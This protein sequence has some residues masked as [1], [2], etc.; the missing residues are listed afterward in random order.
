MSR[1][2][3][4]PLVDR[5]QSELH[6]GLGHGQHQ[7]K[8]H[9]TFVELLHAIYP[10]PVPGYRPLPPHL[11]RDDPHA[12]Q[13]HQ[14]RKHLHRDHQGGLAMWLMS[15]NSLDSYDTKSSHPSGESAQLCKNNK[16]VMQMF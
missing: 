4:Q 5:S 7:R 10:T 9:P 8:G 1:P 2:L 15:G 12:V 16:V 14:E 6:L 3:S 11:Q 13:P